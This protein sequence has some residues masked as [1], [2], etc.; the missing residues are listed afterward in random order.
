VDRSRVVVVIPAH[1]EAGT[2]GSVVTGACNHAAVLVVDDCSGDG[3]SAEAECAGAIVVRN[4][5]QLGYEASLDRGTKEAL[6]RGFHYVITMDADGEHSPECLPKFASLLAERDV[7]I[8]LGVRP[9]R[10]RWMEAVMGLYVRTRFGPRDILCGM[11][12]YRAEIVREN[13]GLGIRFIGTEL[14]LKSIANG[15]R[16]AEVMVD[17]VRRSGTPRFG[18]SWRANMKILSAFCELVKEGPTIGR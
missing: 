2:I 1:N 4:R 11:K 5:R 13:G 9:R 14:A 16:F 18:S 12:G 17:G 3:T 10:Q 7:P 15:A 6:E 8:V